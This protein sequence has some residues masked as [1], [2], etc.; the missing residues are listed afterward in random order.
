VQNSKKAVRRYCLFIFLL[1]MAVLNDTIRSDRYPFME[2]KR[3]TVQQS[4]LI[5]L[6]KSA[7]TGESYVLP[8]GFELGE[9]FQ[10]AKKHGVNLMAY[11]GAV[12]C[13][14]DENIEAMH[15]QLMR[16]YK[17]VCFSEKQMSEARRIL[18]EFEAH[19]V[20]HMPLKGVLLKQLYPHPE[21]R[22]MG[23]A[24]ILVKSE[25]Y[26]T[27]SAIMKELGYEEL[28]ESDHEFI[29]EK[30]KLCIELHKR[31]IPSY[32]K[33]YY[34]YFG[35]GWKLAKPIDE[36]SFRYKMDS[37][38]E[39]VYLFTH[40]SKHYR[41]SGIGIRHLTDLWVY[42]NS[43]PELD[44]GYIRAEL[45]KLQLLEFYDNVSRTLEAWFG[46]YQGDEKT[47]LITKVV[48]LSGEYGQAQNSKLS[49]VL[50]TVQ[51][52]KSVQAVKRNCLMRVLFPDYSAMCTFFPILR[53]A[54]I[55]LPFMWCIR[56]FMKV[57]QIKRVRN[58]ANKQLAFEADDVTKYKESLNYVGLN[59]NFSE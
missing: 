53:K 14:I 49:G 51:G 19:G 28:T 56:L 26:E 10:I 40:F 52:G 54:P 58:Y 20:D 30:G 4:T 6:I 22:R 15:D 50:K 21:M 2:E 35:D 29:W 57:F 27:F 42:Q 9:V 3:M 17:S 36:T 48:F 12:N 23:D 41:D 33:D 5:L 47:E 18:D 43:H 13:G 1:T 24:D 11:Y 38:D 45:E 55:L 44:S 46:D 16:A 8:E 37:N 31:L 34:G 32:N 59:F 7:L 39:F 25:Q